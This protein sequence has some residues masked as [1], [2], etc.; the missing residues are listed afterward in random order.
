M[1]KKG[2]ATESVRT[3]IEWALTSNKVKRV[4]AECFEDNFPS[5]K[6]L[7]KLGM[8]RTGSENGMIN[9]ELIKYNG[10]SSDYNIQV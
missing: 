1:Q 5:I 2:I 6:V 3:I 7:E 4:V 8:T 9:W 10:C